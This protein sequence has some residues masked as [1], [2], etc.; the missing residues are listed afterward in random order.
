MALRLRR[1]TG[2]PEVCKSCQTLPAIAVRA[3]LS[4]C[5]R[6]LDQRALRYHDRTDGV[7]P[8][9]AVREEVPPDTPQLRGYGIVFN[10]RSEDLGGFIEMVRPSAATRLDAESPDLR[11]LWNHDSAIPLGRI[12]AGTF[13]TRTTTRGIAV[14][15]TPPKWAA[16]YVETVERRDVQGQS[17][18]FYTLE[19]QWRMENGMPLRE[20]IDIEILEFSGVSFPAYPATTLTVASAGARSLWTQERDTW[21]RLRLAR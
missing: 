5:G 11:Y 2:E 14:E 10:S 7:T 3:G 20:L 18:G 1:W 19:D 21:T 9:P 6:C 17:F 12:S 8:G 13:R 16:N 4:L 15:V